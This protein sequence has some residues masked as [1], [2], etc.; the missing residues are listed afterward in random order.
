[1]HAML[2]V[3]GLLFAVGLGT[4]LARTAEQPTGLAPA[5]RAV[6]S[7]KHLWI[8]IP[9]EGGC[10]VLHHA[11]EMDG[12][13][14]KEVARLSA[15][16][17]ALAAL[18]NKLWIVA[19]PLSASSAS[20]VFALST[21]RNPV[22]GVISYQPSGRLDVL[23]S[24]PAGDRLVAIA[25]ARH[26]LVA[27]IARPEFELI[28]SNPM[29]WNDLAI[30]GAG[31]DS[32]MLVAWP[33]LA[34]ST[35][36]IVRIDGSDLQSWSPTEQ[37]APSQW[38]R[39]RW[40][41]AGDGLELLITGSVRPAAISH[42][43]GTGFVLQYLAA[44]GPRR[45]TTLTPPDGAW[46]VVGWGD[47]FRLVWCDAR[48]TVHLA[49]IDGVTGVV[50]ESRPLTPQPNPTG[51][52]I[53]LPILGALTIGMLLAGFIIHPPMNPPAA[54][55]ADWVAL[56][57]PRR[58]IA[59]AVDLIPGAVIALV[60]T[61]AHFDELFAM[62]SWTPDLTRSTPSSIM[63]G[64]TGAWCL[65]FEVSLRATPGK[66]LVGGRVVSAPEAGGDLRAGFS[67]TAARAFLK[68]CV[69]F[70]PALGFL[71]FVHPLQQGLPET[72]TKTIVAR[73]CG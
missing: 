64:I 42:S 2:V 55:V 45:L 4:D 30:A 51:E 48:G 17:A 13:F 46:T 15:V 41:G 47:E 71:A 58:V 14:F 54:L 22:N 7:G 5:L 11:A 34:A 28:E 43:D 44:A 40:I 59:L 35:W 61:G 10:K 68:T 27:L 70:A 6:S 57:L 29:R 9:A 19:A 26:G 50:A 73:R 1:M 53:H 36:A 49:Q 18:D 69:L 60:V 3:S 24:I 39:E 32:P 56:S 25:P 62:P 66:F 67:R 12:P 31:G 33:R 72:I 20:E 38:Q 52:W 16:P 37:P 63:L 8:A 21:E 65:L 23:P